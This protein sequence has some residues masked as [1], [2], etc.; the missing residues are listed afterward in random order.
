MNGLT[1]L[2][3]K[4]GFVVL[5][6]LLILKNVRVRGRVVRLFPSLRA[7]LVLIITRKTVRPFVFSLFM[8]RRKLKFLAFI[9][10]TEPLTRPM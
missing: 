10:V 4:M 1:F 2:A 7:N 5:L 3:V 6:L 8:R 9:M